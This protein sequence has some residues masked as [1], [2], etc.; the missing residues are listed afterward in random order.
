MTDEKREVMRKYIRLDSP[1]GLCWSI[2]QI[3]PLVCHSPFN[4]S[5]DSILRYARPEVTRNSYHYFYIPKKDGRKRTIQA[6]IGPLKDIQTCLNFILRS[7]WRPD[8]CVHGFANGRSIISGAKRHTGKP[9]VFNVD[10]KDFFPSVTWIKVYAGLKRIHIPAETAQFICDLCT[11]PSDAC[12]SFKDV[13]P[14]GAPTSPILS[15][16]ACIDL[17][18]R[19]SG[20]ANSFGLTYT[21]YADDITFSS[22]YNIYQEKG[23]FRELLIKIIGD[24]GFS[25]NDKK[26]RLMKRGARQEVTG[27]T[28]CEKVNIPRRW[29]KNFRAQI[30]NMKVNGFTPEEY[31]SALG[32][33]SWVKNIDRSKGLRLEYKIREMKEPWM[34]GITDA[35]DEDNILL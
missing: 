5:R 6:P 10:L 35:A 32:K 4:D 1:D 30:H 20:L 3:L 2:L 23:E 29:I 11:V 21:R 28:V 31:R 13:L 17:D 22:R 7:Y 16:I 26:T 18:R 24:E 33:A 14:Q 9:Y 27:L 34:V 25:L 15:N 12:H 8:E 19:L